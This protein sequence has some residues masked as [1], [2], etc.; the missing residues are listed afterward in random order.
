MVSGEWTMD[1]LVPVMLEFVVGLVRQAGELLRQGHAEGAALLHTKQ[2]A[3]DLVTETDLAS[4]RLLIGALRRAYP[5]HAVLGEESGEALPA[6]GPVWV[7]DPLDGTTN[8]THGFPVFGVSV[9]LLVDGEPL[10]GAVGDPLRDDVFW[11]ARGGGAWRNGQPLRVSTTAELGRSL[12]ATGFGYDR[13][14]NPDNN[15]A[16]FSYFMPKTRGVRRAGAAAL[17]MAWLAAGWLDGYWEKGF[18]V[19]DAAAGVLLIREAGGVAATY[20][21]RPWRPGD[22]NMAASNGVP[23]MHAALLTGL[24]TAR[25]GLPAIG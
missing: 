20:S 8:F 22:R 5:N 3:V 13:A 6:S 4:E 24:H 11:A 7:V 23:S 15:L 17:D 14:T 9:A 2:S 12:L 21:G 16:E 1:D 19:W 25:A 10:L 18:Q